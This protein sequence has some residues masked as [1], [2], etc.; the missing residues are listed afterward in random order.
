MESSSNYDYFIA[1]VDWVPAHAAPA[2]ERGHRRKLFAR[3][4]PGGIAPRRARSGPRFFTAQPQPGVSQSIDAP[5]A[6]LVIGFCWQKN[7]DLRERTD[8]SYDLLRVHVGAEETIQLRLFRSEA[9]RNAVH[10]GPG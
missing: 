9:A 10:F 4:R 7:R 8:N 1:W 6:I 3:P 5:G 2:F